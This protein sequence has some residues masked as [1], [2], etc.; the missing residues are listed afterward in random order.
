M[1]TMKTK[2][3]LFSADGAKPAPCAFFAS[4]EGCR[5]G[6]KCK[7]LH[8]EASSPLKVPAKRDRSHSV[9]SSESERSA[10]TPIVP[11]KTK[12]AMKECRSSEANREAMK[13][14]SSSTKRQNSQG[15]SDSNRSGV[16]S[17]VDDKKKT[18]KNRRSGTSD[19]F[20]KPHGCESS[21]PSKKAKKSDKQLSKVSQVA[22]SLSPRASA[23]KASQVK[24]R[25]TGTTK[26]ATPD[27]RN[28]DLPVASF[29][30]PG[31]E[32]QKSQ[33]RKIDS[34]SSTSV[35]LDLPL[36]K[37][38]SVGRMW[39]DGVIKTRDHSRYPGSYDFN[40]MMEQDEASGVAK[41]SD[42]IKPKL[43]G[44]WCEKNPQSIAI[45]CEMCQTKDPVTGALNHKALCRISVVNAEKPNE[46]LLDTLVKPAWPVTDHRTWVN[47]IEKKHLE[48]V[49]F[50]IRHAQAF[51]MALCSEETLVLGHAVH[52]DLAAMRMEHHCVVDSANLFSVKDE[53]GKTPSLKDVAKAIL[54]EDMPDTHD[55]V[56][57][58]LV[59]LRCLEAWLEKGGDVEP[60]ERT[61]KPVKN[62][63]A[64]SQLFMHR[65]PKFCQQDHFITMF[66]NHTSI[67]AEE[68]DPIEFNGD[69]GKTLVTFSSSRHANLA[70][71]TLE[72]E[73]D[74]DASGRLQKKI[75][76]RDGGYIR[77]RKMV[78]E[79]NKSKQVEVDS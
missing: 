65:I 15:S 14:S 10:P 31:F 22:K 42:W 70:F 3:T 59:S 5:N 4:P 62:K 77:V 19:I 58:A 60:V 36:P 2:Y 35:G 76:L 24:P 8:G 78:H 66:L 69:Y 13:D 75:F 20:A 74:P 40:R 18:K 37:S 64:A 32:H 1:V 6:G 30:I 43:F 52:N 9:V 53:P 49:Q 55:S 16:K 46:V 39:M 27:Y 56:N 72:G 11:T 7:F 61:A 41:R 17:S 45:D 48:N 54:K 12:S 50:T 44:D 71:S 38:T 29:S 34:T 25:K 51:M 68:V 73:E 28:L 33:V 26:S 67:Q 21:R 79:R 23:E 57:D 63:K 47:G